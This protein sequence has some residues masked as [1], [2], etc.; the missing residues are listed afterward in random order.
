MPEEGSRWFQKLKREAK[1]MSPHFRFVRIQLG[2]YRIYW[3][4]AYIHEVYKEMPEYGYDID[5]LD[6]RLHD[7]DYYEDLED[8][9]EL[10]RNI[11]NYV[12]GYYDSMDKLRTRLYMMR[13]DKEFNENAKGAY[14][15]MY[16]T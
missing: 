5:D 10:T 15:Q 12:E 9:T 6:P 3:Q 8:K 7:K 14:K 16:V 1:A 13:N 4:D 11:K 2:F